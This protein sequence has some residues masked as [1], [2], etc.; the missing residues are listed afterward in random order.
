MISAR[1]S[2]YISDDGGDL[3]T[4]VTVVRRPCHVSTPRTRHNRG[5]CGDVGID[6]LEFCKEG[7][8]NE[9]L[10][11]DVDAMTEEGKD[12][13]IL[14]AVYKVASLYLGELI[15]DP[16]F[17]RVSEFVEAGRRRLERLSPRIRI[18]DDRAQRGSY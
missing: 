5:T 17:V 8:H 9:A 3:C 6:T 7:F 14:L 1:T 11:V 12:I 2:V 13:A 10:V 18:H 15:A 16:I 4:R